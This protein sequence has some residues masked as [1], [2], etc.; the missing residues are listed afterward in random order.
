MTIKELIDQL[1]L[2]EQNLLVVLQEDPEGNGYRQ[3]KGIDSECVKSS[4]EFYFDVYSL[5]YS[6]S[7]NCME[8]GEWEDLKK[9]GQRVVVLYP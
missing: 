1:S 4:G 3:L 6:A 5:S 7:D 8:E 9:N 2:M